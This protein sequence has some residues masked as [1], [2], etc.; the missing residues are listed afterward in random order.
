[1]NLSIAVSSRVILFLLIQVCWGQQRPPCVPKKGKVGLVIGQDYQSVL[2]YTR[3]FNTPP[4]TPFGVSSY[5]A[6]ESDNGRLTGLWQPID[7]GSG[8][9][10]AGG[11]HESYPHS[12]LQLGLYLVGKE[13]AV[14]EGKLDR[15][16]DFLGEFLRE[17]VAPV[18]LRIGYEFDSAQNHY[19]A[20]YYV[21]AFKRIVDRMRGVSG[22]HN[23][24]F[25]WHSTGVTPRD[26]LPL[27]A[28]Y[29]GDSYVDWCGI[30]L[31]QQPFECKE[32]YSFEGCMEYVFCSIVLPFFPCL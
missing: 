21:T 19:D 7:Y 16:V 22:A 29:P 30:S 4:L 14:A 23:V 26:G 25:V 13:R 6:L 3:A 24:A 1:M 28:W 27:E 12:A 15:E 20:P 31:F 2:N 18:Y 11:Y 17:Y 32:E 8:I 5:T 9:Q 10:W